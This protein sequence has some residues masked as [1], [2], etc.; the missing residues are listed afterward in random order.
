MVTA[1]VAA[2]IA[3]TVAVVRVRVL[4]YA[5]PG[6]CAQAELTIAATA[7][8]ACCHLGLLGFFITS[9]WSK[10]DTVS[11]SLRDDSL[12]EYRVPSYRTL[13][14]RDRRGRPAAPS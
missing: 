9:P 10:P 3:V 7:R 11:T 13:V 1:R 6:C 8:I 5:P 2:S 4:V 12:H 14:P